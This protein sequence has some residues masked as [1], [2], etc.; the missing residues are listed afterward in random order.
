MWTVPDHVQTTVTLKTSSFRFV[1]INM[2]SMLLRSRDSVV[3]SGVDNVTTKNVGLTP[4]DRQI[5][6]STEEQFPP[7]T[8]TT[9]NV[10]LTE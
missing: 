7:R 4:P 5:T 6:R 9:I 10:T 2:L 8:S 1:L 3:S